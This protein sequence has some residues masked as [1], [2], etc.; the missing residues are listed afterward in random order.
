VPWLLPGSAQVLGRCL[1]QVTPCSPASLTGSTQTTLVSSLHGQKLPPWPPVLVA[2]R[3][4]GTRHRRFWRGVPGT[5]EEAPA[6]GCSPCLGGAA[7]CFPLK[8]SS[9]CFER[10]S[11][12]RGRGGG[13]QRG[14]PCR[15]CGGAAGLK[16]RRETR[17]AAGTMP[18][19]PGLVL[20][21]VLPWAAGAKPQLGLT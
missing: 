13:G 21:P 10:A 7:A 11:E 20:V 12:Q 1:G 9:G 5:G 3:P 18:G 17:N 2:E 19:S 16:R 8:G 15:S 4:R 6:L 14:T